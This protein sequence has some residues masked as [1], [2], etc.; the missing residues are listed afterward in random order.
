MAHSGW[1]ELTHWIGVAL[2]APAAA[3]VLF[4]SWRTLA[5]RRALEP[6]AEETS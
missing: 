4:A 1:M 5:Q 6:D 3:I 2:A